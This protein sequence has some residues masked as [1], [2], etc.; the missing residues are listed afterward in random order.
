MYR[1]WGRLWKAKQQTAAWWWCR[2]KPGV[3][4][5]R[6]L[7]ETQ[8]MCE[9][10]QRH[11]VCRGWWVMDFILAVLIFSINSAWMYVD[12]V[13]LFL[14]VDRICLLMLHSVHEQN[15]LT[16]HQ[17]LGLMIHL[18]L[19]CVNLYT[20]LFPVFPQVLRKHLCLLKV[21]CLAYQW[22]SQGWR[23]YLHYCG[24]AAMFVVVY[25][26]KLPEYQELR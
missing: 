5:E 4:D 3:E 15:E 16:P 8:N 25:L 7:E 13:P 21:Y 9:C 18:W 26:E 10:S 12:L 14:D 11:V 20:S 2:Q 19:R 17:S 6:R 22:Q 1:I 24:Q 23:I